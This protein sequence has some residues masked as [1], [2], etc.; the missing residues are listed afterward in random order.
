MEG[1]YVA[2]EF[3]A[4]EQDGEINCHRAADLVSVAPVAVIFEGE[5]KEVTVSYRS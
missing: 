4:S 1:Q 5:G 2:D 3:H